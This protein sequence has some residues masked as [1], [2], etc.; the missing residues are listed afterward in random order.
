[1]TTYRE[2][3]SQLQRAV[4][5]ILGQALSSLELILVV[6][7]DDP[8]LEWLQQYFNDGRLI[9]VAN[10]RRLGRSASYNRALDMARGRYIA[11]MDGDDLAYPER[12]ARQ[13]EFLESHPSIGLV[14][15][16]VRLIDDIGSQVGVRFFPSD[17]AAILRSMSLTNPICHPAVM[18]NRTIVGEPRFDHRFAA[19]CDD[20]ELW[21]RLVKKGIRFAN[22]PVT[23]MDY[24]QPKKYCR[25][26]D[27]WRLNRQARL[28]HWR[29]GLLHPLFFVGIVSF[30]TISILPQSIIDFIIQRNPLSDRL[31]SIRT[32]DAD[33]NHPPQSAPEK[34]T[35]P[36][37][38]ARL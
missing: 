4:D 11:R 29:L 32:S 30:V 27:N 38:R 31:R 20:L 2:Q 26:R 34:T 24:R 17:H 5:S 1:M 33:A 36:G 35:A 22:L 19:Y 25:P 8:N 12:L 16:A 13:V 15:S 23:L 9:V 28:L 21:L 10:E 6:E 7:A 3:P 37:W 14:G 18:W